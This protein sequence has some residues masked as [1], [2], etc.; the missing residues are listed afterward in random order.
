MLCVLHVVL[1][2]DESKWFVC[3]V[4]AYWL[5]FLH[6]LTKA[7]DN[8]T[9]TMTVLRSFVRDYLGEPVPEETLTHPPS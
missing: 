1:S 8:A 3:I 5:F 2:I 7:A 6:S 9:T 4:C